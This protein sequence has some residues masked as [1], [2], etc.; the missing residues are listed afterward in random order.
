MFVGLESW[1]KYSK[2]VRGE[3]EEKLAKQL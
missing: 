2:Q 1:E 3:I